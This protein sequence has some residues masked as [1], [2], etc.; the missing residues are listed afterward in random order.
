MDKVENYTNTN[1]NHIQK[2]EHSA[3]VGVA[4]AMFGFTLNNHPALKQMDDLD[5]KNICRYLLTTAV[6]PSIL[7]LMNITSAV[8]LKGIELEWLFH[9]VKKEGVPYNVF[10]NLWL[11]ED[12]KP[13]G[14]IYRLKFHEVDAERL[15]TLFID[16]DDYHDAMWGELWGKAEYVG[17]ELPKEAMAWL[18]KW[19][20]VPTSKS[21]S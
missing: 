11:E 19:N 7:Q 3:L 6:E 18:T 20:V 5:V 12:M 9:P 14:T 15:R 10:G 1:Y 4:R 21:K 8:H 16:L 13:R 17:D 2:L